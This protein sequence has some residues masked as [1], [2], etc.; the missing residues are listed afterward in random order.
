VISDFCREVDK[1]CALLGYCAA[2]SG[3]FLKTFR[4]KLSV[5]SAG[6]KNSFLLFLAPEDGTDRCPE[7][8]VINY[9]YLLRN[10]PE[11]RSS[12]QEDCIT[13]KLD[14]NLGKNIVQGYIWSIALWY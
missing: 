8:S 7:T 1:N 14:L 6:I 9:L 13:S 4:D 10:D 3:N 12:Q 5:L 11:E 2:S